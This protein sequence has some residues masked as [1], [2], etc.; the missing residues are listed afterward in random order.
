[1]E[2]K[3]LCHIKDLRVDRGNREVLN[4]VNLTIERGSPYAIVGESGSGKT[5]LLLTMTGLIRPT[6]GAVLY[7]SKE[8]HSIAVPKRAS[9]FGLVFQDYQL[10]PHLTAL[11]NLMLAPRLRKL[12]INETQARNLLESLGVGSLADRL[13][14]NMS[15]GQKQ[16]IAIARSLLLKPEVLYLDEPSAALDEKTTLQLADLLTELNKSIQIVAVSHDRPFLSRF[17]KRGIRM[18]SGKVVADGLLSE[19]LP[20]KGVT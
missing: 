6:G 3:L 7:H 14:A 11:E 15:G 4:S 8:L 16:R 10:F 9:L 20:E 1:M 19:I 12:A 13:P 18:Q 5:T 2:T 17:A